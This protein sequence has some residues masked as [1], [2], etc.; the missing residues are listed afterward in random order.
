MLGRGPGSKKGLN[1][2]LVCWLTFDSADISGTTVTDKSGMG[3]NG[4]LVNSPSQVTGKVNG[5]VSLNGSNQYVTVAHSSSINL[6]G[7]SGSY[8]ITIWAN[9]HGV[10]STARL[11]EKYKSFTPFRYPVSFQ[12]TINLSLVIYD[13]TYVPYV[14]VNNAGNDAWHH[15]GLTVDN[16]NTNIVGYMDGSSVSSTSNTVTG[17]TANTDPL[18]IGSLGGSNGNGWSGIVDEFRIHTRTLSSVEFNA[19][20]AMV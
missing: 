15:I 18:F 7:L 16:A 10:G 6:D 14:I 12:G 2:G 20:A 19:L 9:G 5:A 3:N 1:K 8:T 11:V 17:T 4:T 13:G